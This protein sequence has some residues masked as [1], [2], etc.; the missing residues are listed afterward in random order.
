M[1]TSAIY[2]VHALVLPDPKWP[3]QVAAEDD[4]EKVM[5]FLDEYFDILNDVGLRKG[6][7]PFE[8]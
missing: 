4:L 5:A 2:N 7:A 3:F 6:G 1:W 8:P